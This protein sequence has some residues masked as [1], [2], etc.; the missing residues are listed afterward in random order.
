[1]LGE[2]W[3]PEKRH[4]DDCLLE[5]QERIVRRG[6]PSERGALQQHCKGLRY[7]AIPRNEL[8]VIPGE[9][10]ETSQGT[11]RARTGPRRYRGHLH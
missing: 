9:T 8:A 1:M 3:Q 10:E 6:C 2:I 5:R 4:L 7:G 11:R